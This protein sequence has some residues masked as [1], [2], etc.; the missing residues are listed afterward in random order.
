MHRRIVTTSED[1]R[2]KN[3]IQ[4]RIHRR[5]PNF[6][7]GDF[8]LVGDPDPVR[9][10]GRKLSLLWKGPFR[11]TDVLN[12]Y[13]FE[14]ENIVNNVKVVHGDRVRFYADDKL[15]LTEEIKDQFSYD[16]ASYE[17][18]Q[19]RDCRLN[20]DTHEIEFLVDWKGF[21]RQRALGNPCRTSGKTFPS[22]FKDIIRS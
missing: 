5:E 17:V 7:I 22:L 6:I 9:R 14:V 12:N 18:E 1:R 10:P 19:F 11:V 21:P 20:T 3:R 2:R 4:P 16:N 8:V 15:N 13:I